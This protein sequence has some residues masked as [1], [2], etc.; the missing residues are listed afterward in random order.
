MGTP[1]VSAPASVS[2]PISGG[3]VFGSRPAL[4]ANRPS[5]LNRRAGMGMKLSNVSGMG[6]P[7]KKSSLGGVF[8]SDFQKWS[9]IVYPPPSFQIDV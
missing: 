6:T 7:E 8:G 1:R 3:A 2:G 9:Q 5:A 4:P